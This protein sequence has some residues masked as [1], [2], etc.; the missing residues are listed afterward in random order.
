MAHDRESEG[1]DV[2]WPGYVD[3][4]TNLVLNLL[5]LLTIM[6]IAVFMFAMELGRQHVS[7]NAPRNVTQEVAQPKSATDAENKELRKQLDELKR[8][9]EVEKAK[10]NELRKVLPA[11]LATKKAEKGLDQAIADGGGLIVKFAE[12]AVALT[13]AEADKLRVSLRPF[14]VAGRAKIDVTVPA[15]FSEA[16]RLG[17]YRA[18]AVR[19]LL[20]EL[21]MPPDRIDVSVR[22][23]KSSAD[24][25]LV[26]VAPR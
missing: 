25:S 4:V 5:F 16:R 24:A 2:F 20:V 7:T 1:A 8:Q 21:K 18:M 19:N 13:P 12:D 10:D 11:S 23:G 6:T 3:A 26:R 14:V 15:G 9:I 22:E 17:F